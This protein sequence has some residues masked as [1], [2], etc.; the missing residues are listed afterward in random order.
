M[1]DAFLYV[2]L[3]GVSTYLYTINYRVLTPPLRLLSINITATFAATIY[4]IYLFKVAQKDNIY[5]YHILP[6]VQYTLYGLLFSRLVEP[7]FIKRLIWLSIGLFAGISLF[8][9][10]TI[11]S[12]DKYNSYE[13]TLFN[14]L[15][16]CLSG[17]YLWRIFVDVKV[18]ALEQDA[19]F[20]VAAGL[21]F[22]SLGNFFVQ[23]LM[24]YLITNSV[25]NT[26]TVYLI[27]ELMDFVLFGIFLLALYV[28]LRYSLN[29]NR[30]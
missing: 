4:A 16:A 24:N 9:S 25:S 22:T 28:Y 27:H 20:W 5:I 6:I 10:L 21:F 1:W 3:M 17:Y 2:A 8:L 15:I 18:S 12:W 23:G 13:S 7:V 11:Q 14:V 29:S 26:L 30:R 19:L